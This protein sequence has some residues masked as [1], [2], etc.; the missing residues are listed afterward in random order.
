MSTSGA[1]ADGSNSANVLDFSLI[2]AQKENI[3]SSTRGRSVAA[4]KELVKP[5]QGPSN[6]V[7][8]SRTS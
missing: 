4:L 5:A 7:V 1:V 3:M 6:I 8:T 2:E